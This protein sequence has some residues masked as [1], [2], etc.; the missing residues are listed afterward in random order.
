MSNQDLPLLANINDIRARH[1]LIRLEPNFTTKVIRGKV[2]IFFEPTSE[3]EARGGCCIRECSCGSENSAN[4]DTGRF[5]KYTPRPLPRTECHLSDDSDDD[6]DSYHPQNNGDNNTVGESGDITPKDKDF[7][8]VLDC[9]DIRVRSVSEVNCEGSDMLEFLNTHYNKTCKFTF[10]IWSKRSRDPLQ[11][12]VNPWCI[13]IWKPGVKEAKGFPSV[14]CIDY[15]TTPQG[16]SLLWRCDQDGNPCLFTPAAAINNRSLLPCQDPPFAMATWQA[17]VTVRKEFAVCMTGDSR[18]VKFVGHVEDQEY[19]ELQHKLTS[20]TNCCQHSNDTHKDNDDDDDDDDDDEEYYGSHVPE[21]EIVRVTYYYHTTMVLPVATIAIA[22]G[23][24]ET[25]CLPPVPITNTKITTPSLSGPSSTQQQQQ[26][27]QHS[28]CLHYQYP[29]HHDTENWTNTTPLT[30]VHPISSTQAVKPL[31]AFLPY[32]LRAAIKLLGIYPCRRLEVVVLPQ[33]FGSLGLASPNLIFLSPTVIIDD[34]SAYIRLA[35]EISHAWFG[36]VLGAQD[37]TEEWL[38]EGFAT[39]MEDSIYT[40]AALAYHLASRPPS[41]SSAPRHMCH[42]RP[43]NGTNEEGSAGEEKKEKKEK[44]EEEKDGEDEVMEEESQ[45][46]EE[47]KEKDDEEE[48]KKKKK[49]IVKKTTTTTTT[50]KGSNNIEKRTKKRKKP[51]KAAT[52]G[53]DD[54]EDYVVDESED[55]ED[56]DT[57]SV[58]EDNTTKN[59]NK[60][61]A[62]TKSHTNNSKNGR[63]KNTDDEGEREEHQPEN[64]TEQDEEGHTRPKTTTMSLRLC[65]GQTLTR[66]QLEELADL[67]AHIRY[68]TLASE[69][70][71]SAEEL[72]TL[73]PMQGDNLMGSDGNSYVKNGLNPDK[74][75]LQVHYLKGYFLLKYLSGLVGRAKFDDMISQYVSEH[76]GQLVLSRHI[77]DYFVKSFPQVVKRHGVTREALQ[78]TWLNQ[79]GLNEEITDMYSETSNDL[80]AQ[81][82][83]HLQFWEHFDKSKKRSGQTIKRAKVQLDPFVFPDQLVLLLEYLLELPKVYKRTLRQINEYYGMSTQ[84]GDARH[85]WC[86]L[87]I[88]NDYEDLSQ[89]ERF[90]R[91]DQ[92]MGV[93]LYGE[94][95]ISRNTKHTRLAEQMFSKIQEDM[96]E[97]ARMAV[98]SMLYGE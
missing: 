32:A 79:P 58:P 76:H 31:I 44:Q 16:K 9:C 62:S 74:A 94:L 2:F 78:T 66:G 86:E 15:E 60:N 54:D 56:S 6:D 85:R 51:R 64:N 11:Y 96:D 13:K 1:Y 42:K 48:G 8:V 80:V 19:D 40:E 71:H 39:Y 77:L 83:H 90:L 53:S 63:G 52:G 89:V 72:Q 55:Y 81:V 38:S 97:T 4:D 68:R 26:Q 88:K 36:I 12:S 22:A 92:A 5:Y 33:C 82:S 50:T 73:R 27:K 93:Y 98:F 23:M 49:K 91:E 17:W 10:N 18:P 47:E 70:E 24:W 7:E 28:P 14:V 34:P 75:F 65:S 87:V 35:H 59:K 67:R 61:K 95:I 41:S 69:L 43:R 84:C 30:I 29:C 45:S 57:D 21:W 20:C 3:C 37:W 25:Q 46:V